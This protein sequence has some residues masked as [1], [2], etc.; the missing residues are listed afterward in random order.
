MFRRARVMTLSAVG[1]VVAGVLL[2]SE[3]A[4]LH[5]QTPAAAAIYEGARLINGS[6]GPPIDN[7]AFVVSGGRITAVGRA[8]QVQAPAGATRVSLAGKT[9]MP[10]IVD[11]HIHATSE[12]RET[13][14]DQ[15]Q[16]KA[17][18]GV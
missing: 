12:Q 18:F 7:A 5:G 16:G 14:V 4:M 3:L 6:G 9:V 8:G 15:L 13:L 1:F 10:A 17:Y 2:G 11:A